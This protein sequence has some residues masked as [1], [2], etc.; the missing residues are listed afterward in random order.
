MLV[1]VTG[2]VFFFFFFGRC[3][4]FML[5]VYDIFGAI[6]DKVSKKIL[7]MAQQYTCGSSMLIDPTKIL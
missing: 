6:P 3:S 2:P 1:L 4:N 7:L 5:N